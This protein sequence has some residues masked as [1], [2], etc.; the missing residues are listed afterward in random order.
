[1]SFGNRQF[2]M[3]HAMSG[4]LLLMMAGLAVAQNATVAPGAAVPRLDAAVQPPAVAAVKPNTA[5]RLVGT[6]LVTRTDQEEG[7]THTEITLIRFE[8][9]GR[10]K[11]EILSS[12]LDRPAG[13]GSVGRFRI[14]AVDEKGFILTIDRDLDDPLMDRKLTTESQRMTWLDADTLRSADGDIAR[15][16]R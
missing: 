3:S 14:S 11:T 9:N 5:G 6:W 7:R 10:Y 13:R 12:L 4:A 8:E 1:M 2:R 16:K 15:R